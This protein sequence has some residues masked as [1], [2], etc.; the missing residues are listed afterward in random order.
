M[1]DMSTGHKAERGTETANIGVVNVKIPPFWPAD[2]QVWFMEV[3]VQFTTRGIV[4]RCTK[5]D[6]IVASLGLIKF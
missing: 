5:Y 4:Q 3:E 6:Y 2:P 1:D